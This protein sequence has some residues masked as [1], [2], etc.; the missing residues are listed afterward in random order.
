MEEIAEAADKEE[1][2]TSLK[3]AMLSNDIEKMEE[4]LKNKRIHCV[5]SKNG[6]S[7]IRVEDLSLYRNIIMVRDR[8]WAPESITFAFFNNL[9]LG[10]RS[11]EMMHRLAL[12]SVYWQAIAEDLK[13]FFNECQHCDR[14]MDKNKKL[15][16][17]PEEETTRAFECISIDGFHT[18]GG[19]NGLAIIDR[20]TGFLWA[21]ISSRGNTPFCRSSSLIT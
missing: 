2:L 10:H 15:E 11:V 19:E 14:V 20:H 7:A 9:H 6:L 12:R 5:Q 1:F 8:I 18:D 13:S 4:L 16:D 17:L 3:N 21:P